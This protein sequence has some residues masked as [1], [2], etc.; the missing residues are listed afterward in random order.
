MVGLA[1][2]LIAC[3]RREPLVGPVVGGPVGA[4]AAVASVSTPPAP[5]GSSAPPT[6]PST[7][8]SAFGSIGWLDHKVPGKAPRRNNLVI[9]LLQA[10]GN[11]DGDATKR[12]IRKHFPSFRRCW[13]IKGQDD[14]PLSGSVTVRL[15]IS[16]GVV[17]TA[18]YA[19]GQP[20][21]LPDTVS[22]CLTE[23]SRAIPFPS[24]ASGT[25]TFPLDV[26]P[27]SP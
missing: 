17:I 2:A 3:P 8:A 9:G 18:T 7:F 6:S 4:S 14:P 25:V 1:T 26:S 15:Q 21:P 10:K 23:A 16:G 11:V 24:G 20:D 27:G 5:S 13:E 22:A 19:P 12:E